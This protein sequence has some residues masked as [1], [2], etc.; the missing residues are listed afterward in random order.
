MKTIKR[1]FWK[2]KALYL[3]MRPIPKPSKKLIR[4]LNN[5][6]QRRHD[7]ILTNPNNINLVNG[8]IDIKDLLN[9]YKTYK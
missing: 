2:I 3:L 4:S 7:L 6:L 9:L 8:H 5:E 1:L